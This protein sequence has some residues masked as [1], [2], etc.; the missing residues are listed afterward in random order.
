MKDKTIYDKCPV[1]ESDHFLLRLVDEKDAEDLLQCYSDESAVRL[2]N[3]DNC[4]CDFHFQ[5]LSEMN[6]Q[7]RGW[8]GAYKEGAFIRFSIVD[9]Q[10]SKAVGTIEMFDKTKDIGILRLDLCSTY[11]TQNYL[12]ELIGLSTDK[13]HDIYD[14][15]HILIKAIPS[16]RERISALRESD[17]NNTILPQGEIWWTWNEG[18]KKRVRNYIPNDDYYMHD[19]L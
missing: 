14:V 19:R 2:M 12:N 6:D 18:K 13:F 16:A 4:S 9:I 11:E 3:S 17:F 1:Y 8:L 15:Q 7:I 5:T 10:T